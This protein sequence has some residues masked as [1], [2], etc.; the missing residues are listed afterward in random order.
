MVNDAEAAAARARAHIPVVETR[1]YPGIGH[2]LLWANPDE[3]IPH[4]LGFAGR[5]E[6]ARA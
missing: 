4:L 5:H 2:D 6:A 1:L 3:V